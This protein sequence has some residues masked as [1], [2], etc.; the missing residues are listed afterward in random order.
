MKPA[1]LS[2]F[3]A[4]GEHVGGGENGVQGIVGTFEARAVADGSAHCRGREGVEHDVV[5]CAFH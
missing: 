1:L 2:L 5:A 3:P 4:E